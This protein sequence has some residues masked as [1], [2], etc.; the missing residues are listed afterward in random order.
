MNNISTLIGQMTLEE[1]ASLCSGL[2]FWY[3]KGLER[4][5]IPSIMVTDGPHG[6]RK[7]AGDADHVGLNESVPATCFPTASALAATWNRDLVREVGVALGEECRQEQVGV[8]LGPGA[9]IKRSPLGG[10][11]FE[12]FSEDPYLTGEIAKSHINGV[13]SQGVGT[14]IKHYAANSQET[15]RM[16]TDSVLDERTLREIY[17]PGF[18]IAVKEAQP[19]TVMCSYNRINGIYASDNPYLLSDILKNEWGHQ[20]LVVTDWGAMNERVEAI[21][22]GLELEMPGTQNG[23]DEKIVEAVQS[24]DLDEAV[25]DQ[26]V[27]RV[28]NLIFSAEATL[29]QVFEYDPDAHHSLARRVAGEGAVLLKNEGNELP[30]SKTAK[31]ALVGRFAKTPRYQGAGSSRMNPSRLDNLYNELT[32]LVSEEN[33]IYAPGYDEKGA[34]DDIL[35]QEALDVA[36]KADV[37]V[38]HAGLMDIDEVEGLDRKHLHLPAG[39]NR[40]IE[41]IAS[42]HEH[43][44]VVLSNGAP[45][46]M[47]WIADVEAVLEGY[48]GGQAGGGALADILT[49]EVNPSGKLAETFPIHL[50]DTPA[51]PFP[52]GPTTVEYRESLYVGYRWYDTA[53]LDVLFPFGHGLSYTS[54]DYSDLQLKQ[55]DDSVNVSF[56][57]KNTG[58]R[59][60]KEIAQVYVRDI[61]STHFRPDK[62]LKGFEKIELQP[63]EEI[64]VNLALDPRAFAYYDAGSQGWVVEPGAFEIL[65][66]ASSRDI[67]LQ[68]T[69]AMLGSGTV[70]PVDPGQL[71][72]YYA[73]AKGQ[74]FGVA[75]FETLLGRS[76]P[77]NLPTVKGQYTLNTPLIEMQTSWIGRQFYKMVGKNIKKMI[78]GNED[79]PEGLLIAAMVSEMPLRTMLMMGGPLDRKKLEALVLMMNGKFF[80]G[81]IGVIK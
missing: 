76:V 70:S 24:G 66:G 3:L 33:L 29:K 77:L 81:L 49:G 74:D 73:P 32:M 40:L 31:I 14:S 37:V 2:N 42:A 64:Q 60:G 15:R 43:V 63:G 26:T 38:I 62:E 5:G 67:R 80:R 50:A 68:A 46:E 1:K 54:F 22:A 36:S 45:V 61:E 6:L 34:T 47:P 19:W 12:Y 17:L 56:K 4:L 39:H 28:L 44:V 13:Q 75:E 48:L 55:S 52:G 53:G 21:K 27:E 51:Q 23:N 35:L 69:V 11:N 58:K 72:S 71:T 78:E 9:N 8:I 18:E 57:V 25:L 41:K 79:S 59:A 10:R 16:T 7:Q 65:I 20:G 30:V